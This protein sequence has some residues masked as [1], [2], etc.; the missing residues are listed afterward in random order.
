MGD[1]P[2]GCALPHMGDSSKGWAARGPVS[3]T[4][5]DN[6]AMQDLTPI[7]IILRI[8]TQGLTQTALTPTAP[9]KG[10]RKG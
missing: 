4:E 5:F 10:Q 2:K 1:S 6:V 8:T 3:P 9:G 7:R